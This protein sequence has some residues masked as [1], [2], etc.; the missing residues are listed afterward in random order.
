MSP[1]ILRNY[2]KSM[3][4]TGMDKLRPYSR[5][6]LARHQLTPAAP[7]CRGSP[8]ARIRCPKP[9]PPGPSIRHAPSVLRTPFR[10]PESAKSKA[11]AGGNPVRRTGGLKENISKRAPGLPGVTA[12]KQ[13]E[14]RIFRATGTSGQPCLQS[15]ADCGLPLFHSADPHELFPNGTG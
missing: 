14:S 13:P 3:L 11:R 4:F 10:K 12:R 8:T 15:R 1:K 7:N 9:A 5:E 2:K 6:I